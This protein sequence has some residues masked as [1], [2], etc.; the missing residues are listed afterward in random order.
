MIQRKVD[1]D[2]RRPATK[3]DLVAWGKLNDGGF[4]A[5]AFAL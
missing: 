1:G 3:S 2:A 5:R 4:G